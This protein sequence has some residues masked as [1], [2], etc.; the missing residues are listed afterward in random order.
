MKET[1]ERT[2]DIPFIYET[3]VDSYPW[4][5][6]TPRGERGRMFSIKITNRSNVRLVIDFEPQTFSAALIDSMGRADDDKRRAFSDA[7]S[8]Q[9][10]RGGDVR[11]RINGNP[12]NPSD[13][14]SWPDEPWRRVDCQTVVILPNDVTWDPKGVAESVKE[15][16][17]LVMG[18]FLALVRIDL[19][20]KQI[21]DV[22]AEKEGDRFSVVANRYERST[23]NRYLCLR[24]YGYKCKVCGFDFQDKYGDVGKGY[25]HVHHI[26][27]VSQIG[28][29]YQIDPENDLI[30]VCPN[31]H[32]M[33]HR[34]NPPYKPD[35]ISSMIAASR[36]TTGDVI[37][38]TF[39]RDYVKAA[40]R[41]DQSYD[42]EPVKGTTNG[43][44]E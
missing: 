22:V 11:M 12:V 24:K 26:V 4:V 25:I 41:A 20:E 23:L 38:G 7:I 14:T 33:L 8:L 36:I 10:A 37:Y 32:A 34:R 29:G 15:W 27:P 28:P 17:C 30:P 16:G 3:G 35:E 39:R 44:S 13:V 1:L 9:K 6:I 42:V 18:T 5:K 2:F 31:C 40:D 43:K 19:V 21:P